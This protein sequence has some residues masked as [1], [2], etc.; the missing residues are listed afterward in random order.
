MGLQVSAAGVFAHF[1]FEHAIDENEVADCQAGD[2]L[3]A[4]GLAFRVWA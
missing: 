4:R 3:N 1:A 2:V